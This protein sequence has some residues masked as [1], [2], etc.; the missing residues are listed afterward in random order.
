MKRLVL[1]CAGMA[2]L[3]VYLTGMAQ[4]YPNRP[5]RVIVAMPPGAGQDIMLR[6]IGEEIAPRIGQPFVI[7]NRPGGA[8]IPAMEAC[9]SAVPDGHN[10]CLMTAT[11]Q[12]INPHVF[13][14]LPYDVERDYKPIANLYTQIEALMV[15]SKVPATTPREL[16]ALAMARSGQMNYGTLGE[17]TSSD[18]F[19]QM[20]SDEWGAKIAGIPYKGGNLIITALVAGEVDMAWIGAYNAIGQQKAGKVRFLAVGSTKRLRLLP[21]LPTL[22]ELNLKDRPRPPWVA[23]GAPAATPD[24]IIARLNT[25]LGRVFAEPKFVDYIETQYIESL[26]GTPQE[27]DAYMRRDRDAY[28]LVVKKYNLPKQ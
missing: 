26:F 3:G 7:D 14:K 17:A 16:Q 15:A 9:K 12:S 23:I 6:K 25:E 4:T 13:N 2:A 28:G 21:D 22:E 24:S 5:I 18:L 10:L 1:L 27:L 20:L 8:Q 19:R 11:T